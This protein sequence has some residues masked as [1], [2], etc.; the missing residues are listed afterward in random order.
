MKRIGF[1]V[2]VLG[3][4]VALGLIAI[5]QT[6]RASSSPGGADA[7]GSAFVADQTAAA[8]G[9]PPAAAENPLRPAATAS[10]NPTVPDLLPG[11]DAGALPLAGDSPANNPA[12]GENPLRKPLPADPFARLQ[13]GR[14][15]DPVQPAAAQAPA[16]GDDARRGQP[17]AA[18][19][20]GPTIVP[21]MTADRP[22]GPP[23]GADPYA[24]AAAAADTQEP[25]RFRADAASAIGNQATPAGAFAPDAP[26]SPPRD[27]VRPIEGPSP[28]LDNAAAMEGTGQPGGKQLEG[29]QSPQLTIEKTCPREVQVGKPATFHITVRNSG[30][31]TA[32][33]VEIRD[34]IPRGTRLL[35]TTPPAA[36]GPRGELVWALG[37]LHPG[38]QSSVQVQLLPTAEGEIGSVATVHFDA[39]VAARTLATQPKLVIEAAGTARV[40]VGNQVNL[41]ITVSNPGSGTASGV[42][43]EAHLPPGVQHPAGSEL[44]YTVGQLRPGESRRLDLQLLANR[45]GTLT[46]VLAVRGE[47]R[48]RC[49]DRYRLEVTAPQLDLT[50]TGPKH[51]YLERE[52]TYQVAISNPGT[53]P[54]QQVELVAY[55]PSGLK[56]LSANNSGHY[57]E[58][59]RAVHWR[60]EELPT[61]QQ[62]VVELV[63]MPVEPGQQSIKLRG[64][65]AKGLVVER[66]QPVVIDGVATVLFQV[67]QDA[68]PIEVGGQTS[69]QVRL[70]NQGSKAASN[71]RLSVL[72]PP[73]LKAVDAEGPSRHVIEGGRVFFDALERLAP[74]AELTYRVRVQGLQPGD[75]RVRC[76][77]LTDGMQTPVTKEEGTQVY[78]D[79]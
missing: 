11:G 38:E 21:P 62:G 47:G 9:P 70:V 17:P 35:D 46:S 13:P 7:T 15:G 61:N 79:Q 37:T 5:A 23:P 45:P 63:T 52:A 77:L 56:F 18:A 40:L 43:V 50:M 14:A 76:Q 22:A 12:P 44:E 65:A 51:R 42:V 33:N 72:L 28:G 57:E 58:A 36:R 49:E 2:A 48:L 31:A 64:T 26:A 27:L 19:E 10:G 69:Y 78:A 66:E 53:A 71:V 4:V 54:A 60:L 25:R 3:S 6:Q 74:K 75:L 30:Q 59:D 29:P 34:P 67:S 41:A 55:L 39:D 8:P 20:P 1:R 16:A 73:E 24:P 68:N 32:G